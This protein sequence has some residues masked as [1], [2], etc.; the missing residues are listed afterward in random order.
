MIH[1][2][3]METALFLYCSVDSELAT[4][5]KYDKEKWVGPGWYFILT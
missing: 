2:E 5:Y 4:C 1:V 3:D